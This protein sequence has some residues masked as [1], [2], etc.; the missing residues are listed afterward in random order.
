[1]P[2]LTATISE[3]DS[4]VLELGIFGHTVLWHY[5]TDTAA[6]RAA[7]IWKNRFDGAWEAIQKTNATLFT[8][9]VH[10]LTD[11]GVTEEQITRAVDAMVADAR[12]QS[13]ND[14]G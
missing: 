13:E 9:F 14:G 4:R 11:A 5:S 7:H 3:R 12:Q 2:D 10:H 6:E 8:A 1:M